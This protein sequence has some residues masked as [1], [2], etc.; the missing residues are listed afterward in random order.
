M[1]FGE[2]KK[3][4][5]GEGGIEGKEGWKGRGGGGRGEEGKERNEGEKR[6]GK[7]EEEVYIVEQIAQALFFMH[8]HEPPIVHLDIK[9]E[10]I[11]V[12]KN[13]VCK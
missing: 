12:R 4:K 1:W 6:K 10:N 8:Q 9:P 7:E 13:K 11:L 5:E 3:E 2:G